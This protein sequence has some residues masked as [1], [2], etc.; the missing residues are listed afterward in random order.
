[1]GEP[2]SKKAID[3]LGEALRVGELPGEDALRS[4]DEWRIG[5]KA[6]MQGVEAILRQDFGLSTGSRLKTTQTIVEKLRRQP[7]MRLSRMQDIAG[8]RIV[9]DMDLAEQDRVATRLQA[10][11]G[12]DTRVVDR[13]AQPSHGYRAVHVVVQHEGRSC[14]IQIRTT[15]QSLWAMT[16]ERFAAAWGRQIQYGNAPVDPQVTVLATA[17]GVSITRQAVVEALRRWSDEIA[18]VESTRTLADEVLRDLSPEAHGGSQH[19]VAE[20]RAWLPTAT[21]AAS[22]QSVNLQ[23]LLQI[24]QVMPC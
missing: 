15:L 14:E 12:T 6:G 3:R 21:H 16:M 18:Q 5:H 4:L 8:V 24:A 23:L 2:A 11:F 10:R 9:A 19:C 17:A 1:M 22:S 20:S 7:G 13:R